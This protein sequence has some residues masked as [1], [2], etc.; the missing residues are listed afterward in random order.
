MPDG[1]ELFTVFLGH[2]KLVIFLFQWEILCWIG[3]LSVGYGTGKFQRC[4]PG[5]GVS[6]CCQDGWHNRMASMTYE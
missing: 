6:L 3:T 1:T 5:T 4:F 2:I